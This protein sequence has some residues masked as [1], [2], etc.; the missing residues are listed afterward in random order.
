M[1]V[2]ARS[3]KLVYRG[4]S[5]NDNHCS[6]RKDRVPPGQVARQPP[7]CRWVTSCESGFQHTAAHR[8]RSPPALVGVTTGNRRAVHHRSS[9]INPGPRVPQVIR[10]TMW[11]N[12]GRA[13]RI[14]GGGAKNE[15][16]G[17]HVRTR[18]HL[19][20]KTTRALR[21]PVK[22]RIM[23]SAPNEENLFLL[24][25]RFSKERTLLKERSS[26]LT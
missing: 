18:F 3:R 9:K 23:R 4:I 15:G 21:P 6:D 8:S 19:G 2:S 17:E 13:P 14:I 12:L 25:D 1:R 7:V 22:L 16:V 26:R 11:G 20:L 24:P 5:R 10:S